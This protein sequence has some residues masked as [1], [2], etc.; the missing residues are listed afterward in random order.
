MK[1]GM[2]L[3]VLVGMASPLSAAE[4]KLYYL[5]GQ[6]NMEGFGY[7]SELSEPWAGPAERV[8]EERG[9][10]SRELQELKLHRERREHVEAGR[11]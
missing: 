4:Y 9:V 5:G 7:V 6:S 1:A 11:T 2:V 10:G 8:G 3:A